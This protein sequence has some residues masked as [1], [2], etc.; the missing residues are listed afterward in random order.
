M[1][2]GRPPKFKSV[3]EFEKLAEAYFSSCFEEVWKDEPKRDSNGNLQYKDG[4][5]ILEPVKHLKQVEPFTVTGLALALNTTR[6]TLM[7]YQKNEKFSD[8]VKRAKTR[9]ENYSEKKL[10]ESNAAGPIFAL[11]NFGWR[12]KIE[13]E[14]SG[15]VNVTG[16]NVNIKK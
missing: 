2:G 1:P 15:G 7:D 11:K 5:I 10:Y 9:V 3:E 14:H 12:D 13:T 6:E 8:A 4:K 16:F